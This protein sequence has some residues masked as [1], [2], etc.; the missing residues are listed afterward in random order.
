VSVLV[1]GW[2][3]KEKKLILVLGNIVFHCHILRAPV[4]L[5]QMMILAKT[6]GVFEC[7]AISLDFE[8]IH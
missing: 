6:K 7:Q 5:L 8:K 2:E 4:E 3:K 1:W